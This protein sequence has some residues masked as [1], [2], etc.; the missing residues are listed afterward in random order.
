MLGRA[1]RKNGGH[2]K[3]QSAECQGGGGRGDSGWV[4]VK[5]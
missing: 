3:V 5:M 2:Q 1:V 4:N